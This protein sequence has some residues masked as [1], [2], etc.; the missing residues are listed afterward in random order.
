MMK[1]LAITNLF[2]NAREP[3]RGVF[4]LQQF[5]ALRRFAE[6]RVVAPLAWQ[7]WVHGFGRP[8]P[9]QEQWRDIPTLHPFYFYTPG[10][11][12]AA[13]AAWMYTSLRTPVMR[14]IREYQPD[15]LLA[16]WA[17]P[18]AVATAA[19]ARRLRLPWV[20][21]VLGSDINVMAGSPL[22]R[23]QIRGALRQAAGT[24]AVSRP[25][26]ERLVDIGV[27]AE[28]VHVL[29]NG[30]DVEHFQLLDM[31]AARRATGLPSDRQIVVYVGNLKVSKGAADLVEAARLLREHGEDAPLVVLV[32]DGSARPL[33][34]SELRRHGLAEHVLLAGARPHAEI[35]TWMAAADVFCLPSHAEGCPNVVLE[36]LACGRPV[37]ASSVGAVPDL[38]DETCGAMVAPKQPAPLADAL[39]EVLT[40]HWDP[41]A[42]R[43]RVLPLS[44]EENA[45]VLAS[46]LQR[47]ADPH[48][49]RSSWEEA[50]PDAV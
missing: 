22:V 8:V 44:W 30:V 23:N 17:Y 36:A 47:A 13:Y 43:A 25:L 5:S 26:K 45:R 4:N 40:R 15:V 1:V 34:D 3:N 35:P 9:Y 31:S 19:L 50:I 24:L 18:E 27:P 20:A 48:L 6:V 28:R 12:R 41:S 37:V 16:A 46:H 32:G 33:L 42:L 11:G 39:R 38:L 2:P 29:H 49:V 7:P 10:I 14:I 21:L